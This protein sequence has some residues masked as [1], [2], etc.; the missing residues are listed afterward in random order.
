VT[1]CGKTFASDWY[2]EENVWMPVDCVR[3][4]GHPAPCQG[5]PFIVAIVGSRGFTDTMLVQRCVR[6]LLA[7]HDNLRIVSGGARGADRQ[8]ELAAAELDVPIVIH[9]AEWDRFGRSAGFRRNE[10][11]VNDADMLVAFFADGPRSRGT[12]HSL[13]LALT[14]GIPVHVYHGGTWSLK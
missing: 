8:A 9:P 4:E 12:T 7:L 1:L 14:K 5:S 2:P 10:T 13:S 6:R 11:I 3:T